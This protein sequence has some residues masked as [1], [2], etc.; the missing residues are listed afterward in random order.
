MIRNLG[1]LTLLAML[2]GVPAAHG[3]GAAPAT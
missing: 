2:L 3:A 1:I